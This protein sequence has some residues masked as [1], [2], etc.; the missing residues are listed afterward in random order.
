MDRSTKDHWTL[1]LKFFVLRPFPL[2]AQLILLSF[3]T[4]KKMAIIGTV[5]FRLTANNQQLY[6][7][8]LMC[9]CT[10]KFKIF[11]SKVS[12]R[13]TFNITG[14]LKGSTE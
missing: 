2:H 4:S 6:K 5:P 9:A 3:S 14:Y 1:T 10:G 12:L 8:S 11:P 13:V 7:G